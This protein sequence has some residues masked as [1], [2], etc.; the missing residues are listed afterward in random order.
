MARGWG[1]VQKVI[2]E[3]KALAAGGWW[4]RAGVL[5]WGGGVDRRDREDSLGIWGLENVHL[6]PA[7]LAPVPGADGGSAGPALSEERLMSVDGG[8]VG[9]TQA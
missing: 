3:P 6:S 8:P 2:P 1:G 9:A 4:A 7:P 5:G